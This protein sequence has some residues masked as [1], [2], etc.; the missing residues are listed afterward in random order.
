MFIVTHQEYSM[1][2]TMARPS[3]GVSDLLKDHAGDNDWTWYAE[4]PAG[5]PP[6]TDGQITYDG[7]EVYTFHPRMITLTKEQ[8]DTTRRVPARPQPNYWDEEDRQKMNKQIKPAAMGKI[9]AWL[10]APGGLVPRVL[11]KKYPKGLGGRS[12]RKGLRRTRRNK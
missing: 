7:D 12:R 2:I 8:V 3:M 5:V 6:P 1:T 10:W 9:N 4:L 11:A